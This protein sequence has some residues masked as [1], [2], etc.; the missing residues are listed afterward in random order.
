MAS[1][2]TSKSVHP[3]HPRCSSRSDSR[4]TNT[5]S[6]TI[7]DT[8]HEYP[9]AAVSSTIDLSKKD[10][11]MINEIQQKT[12]DQIFRAMF[13]GNSQRMIPPSF[14]N[15]YLKQPMIFPHPRSLPITISSSTS[16][17][18]RRLQ[19]SCIFCHEQ[20]AEL[21]HLFQHIRKNHAVTSSTN[22][23]NHN[24]GLDKIVF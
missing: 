9:T 16:F 5:S 6:S 22:T 12:S 20:F 3:K 17:D 10:S 19:S 11:F 7:S 8:V 1:S 15:S 13:N 24:L 2:S 21:N 4:S 18:F 23:K 14:S